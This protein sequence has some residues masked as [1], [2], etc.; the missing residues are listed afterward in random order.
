LLLLSGLS[1][2]EDYAIIQECYPYLARRLFT[3]NSPRSKA[4]LREM[5]LG[6]PVNTLDGKNDA[7]LSPN[8]LME[9]SSGFASYTASTGEVEEGKGSMVGRFTAYYSDTRRC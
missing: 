4:A 5:L 7:I 1:V 2:N 6:A 3:D 8:K 9:M